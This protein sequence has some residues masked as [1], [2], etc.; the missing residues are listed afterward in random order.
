MK[1][2]TGQDYRQ[3]ISRVVEHIHNNLDTQ[4]N[5]NELADVAMMSPYHFH[6][7]YRLMT[8]EAVNATVRRLRLQRAAG[9]LMRTK[10]PVSDV[11]GQLAYGS[12]EAFSRAFA[13]EFGE[14]PSDYRRLHKQQFLDDNDSAEAMIPKARTETHEAYEVEIVECDEVHLAAYSHKGDYLEIGRVFE[15]LDIYV[16]SMGL[17]DESSRSFGLYY[18]DPESTETPNLKSHAC[19]SIDLDIS[20]IGDDPPQKIVIPKGR[21]ASLV[22]KGPYAELE[23]PYNWLFGQWLP[24]SGYEAG[25]YPAIEEYLND[26]RKTSPSDLLTRIYCLILP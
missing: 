11:A 12:V 3:R 24:N 23:K 2:A 14:S 15:Q 4:L 5:V 6:R 9:L 16:N 21:Y 7:I 25:D 26:V 20:L 18:N 8:H 17:F 19:L 13:K 10:Q 22:F 1:P